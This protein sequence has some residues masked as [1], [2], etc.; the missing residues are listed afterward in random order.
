VRVGFGL[1]PLS[2]IV[3]SI[4]CRKQKDSC[5]WARCA[6]LIS[7]KASGGSQPSLQAGIK[8]GI[9]VEEGYLMREKVAKL[10]K[11]QKSKKI[12]YQE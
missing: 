6:R 7:G 9:R 12:D 5:V 10:K 1:L 8:L 2:L 4:R 11:V 3:T